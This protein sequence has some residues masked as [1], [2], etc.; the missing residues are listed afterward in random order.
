[1]S[2][3][4]F[5]KCKSLDKSQNIFN[6]KSMQNIR[7]LIPFI[8][9][10]L[11][12]SN[13][14]LRKSVLVAF[15]QFIIVISLIIGSL[16]EGIYIK[17]PFI[18]FINYYYIFCFALFIYLFTGQ[19]K[20][21]TKYSYSSS[22]Y[23]IG[24]RNIFIG[25]LAYLFNF[26]DLESNNLNLNV[27]VLFILINTI[28]SFLL[29][30][31]LS[32]FIKNI[33][34]KKIA[35][36]N[37]IIYGAGAAGAQLASIFKIENSYNIISFIDDD[38]SLWGRSIYSIQI[39]SPSYLYKTNQKIDKIL[40]A[41]PSINLS[42]R[43]LILKKL[44]KFDIPVYQ[45]P[46]IQELISGKEK[47]DTLRPI[48]VEELLGR[49]PVFPL[50]ELI[51][52]GI[53]K[54]SICITGAGGSIGSELSKQILEFS[55]SKLVLVDNSESNLYLIGIELSKNTNL[56][57]PI[58][59]KLGDCTNDKF[60]DSIFKEYEIDM[61]F[62]AAAYKH[63][64]I[65]EENPLPGIFN[66][67][68]STLTICEASL[69]NNLKKMILISSDK[70]V[71]PTNVMGASKRLAEQI[72]LDF[73]KKN[74]STLK[75]KQFI[76]ETCFSLVRFGNVLG[77]SGSVIPLF[78]KQIR[79]GGPITITHEKI[80]RYFMTLQEA[81]QLVLHVAG[82]SDGG[83]VF[84]LDMGKPVS[85]KY[86]AEQMIK[87]SGSSIK[88]DSS[89]LEGIEIKYTGLRPGEKLF[90]ELLIDSNAQKTSHPLI[91][92][93]VNEDSYCDDLLNQIKLLNDKIMNLEE[94]EA[95][96]ILAKLVPDW[97]HN[98]I[99]DTSNSNIKD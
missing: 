68:I 96:K 21:L 14:Y 58:V 31:S 45:I 42:R 35:S 65:V 11:E 64:P 75:D 92:K 9:N 87:M 46:L 39:R 33:Q 50:K 84:L 8:Y 18:L 40:L 91:F 98:R 15:D 13:F 72:V 20:V 93:G 2:I 34:D 28:F 25:L 73:A 4:K 27:I 30:S 83:E 53:N 99:F 54:K 41:M 90:E 82:I 26:V 95:L 89:D 56:V 43:Q 1:M 3:E 81:A 36:N 10:I 94:K 78:K 17:N 76:S 6:I 80:I 97:H 37:V 85:I 16:L 49:E 19:Y 52:K 60:I 86:L 59:F 61:V 70:A 69:K 57:C 79:E 44:S 67:V 7:N 71:R 47:I 32:W 77:S 38:K 12:N 48:T 23:K 88:K 62:H 5:K 55:P 51:S 74:K 29:R 66:N 22:I 24:L 63:V